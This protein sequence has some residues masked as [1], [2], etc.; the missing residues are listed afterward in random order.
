MR[1][2]AKPEQLGSEFGIGGHGDHPYR[3]RH[4]G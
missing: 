4:F 2:S 1:N 3:R